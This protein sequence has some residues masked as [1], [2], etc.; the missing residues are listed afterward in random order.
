MLLIFCAWRIKKHISLVVKFVLSRCS[1]VTFVLHKVNIIQWYILQLTGRHKNKAGLTHAPVYY[2]FVSTHMLNIQLP[3]VQNV[4]TKYFRYFCGFLHSRLLN[5]AWNSHKLMH[6]EYYHFTV[7][8]KTYHGDPEDVGVLGGVEAKENG[9]G[10]LWDVQWL[11]FLLLLFCKTKSTDIINWEPVLKALTLFNAV[12]M[13]VGEGK[14]SLCTNVRHHR[15]GQE[16]MELNL[17]TKELMDVSSLLLYLLAVLCCF[18]LILII[19]PALN[20]FSCME[21]LHN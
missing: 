18:V 8:R 17:L 11:L 6:R 16:V 4:H 9:A 2:P 15:Y 1:L 3:R 13:T 12:P 5:C 21:E 20:W 10:L 7:W 19:Q 14:K